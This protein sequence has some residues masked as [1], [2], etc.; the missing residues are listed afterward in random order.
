[1]GQS[2]SATGSSGAERAT[3]MVLRAQLTVTPDPSAECTVIAAGAE[4]NSVSQQLKVTTETDREGMEATT[5]MDEACHSQVTFDDGDRDPEYLT[6]DVHSACICPVLMDHDCIPEI[7]GTDG[8][9]IVLVV[10]VPSRGVLRNLLAGL[11]DIDATVSM[12]WLVAD[13]DAET[14]TEIDVSRITEK[15]QE[16][17]ETALKAGYYEKPRTCDMSDLAAELDISKSAVSQRLNAA[18]TKLVKSFMD[19]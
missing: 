18:E 7:Q 8:R 16:A 10:T 15:Q 5:S 11:R 9:S 13:D 3:E 1:M 12:D 14:T 17:L 2:S 4:V 6:S 19:A